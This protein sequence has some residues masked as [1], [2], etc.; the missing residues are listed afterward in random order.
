MSRNS[1]PVKTIKI[2]S[3]TPPLRTYI[4]QWFGT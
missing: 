3:E 2:I 1:I 4:R